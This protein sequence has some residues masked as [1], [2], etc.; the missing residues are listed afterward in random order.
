[1]GMGVFILA[2][3]LPENA[4]HADSTLVQKSRTRTEAS[5]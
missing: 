4:E 2:A 5:R 1:M 3:I